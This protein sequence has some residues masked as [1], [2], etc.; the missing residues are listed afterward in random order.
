MIGA[1]LIVLGPLLP[2]KASQG[3]R[4]ETDY[5]IV[6]TLRGLGYASGSLMVAKLEKKYGIH[7][8]MVLSTFVIGIMSFLNT[9]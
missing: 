3:G 8:I 2:I 7:L 4:K 5:S 1:I 6:F 9:S